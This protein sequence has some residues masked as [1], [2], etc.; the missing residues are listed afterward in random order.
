MSL[1]IIAPCYIFFDEVSDLQEEFWNLQS[2]F[3]LYDE[4]N[5]KQKV[6]LTFLMFCPIKLDHKLNVRCDTYTSSYR[7]GGTKAF[8]LKMLSYQTQL[9][10]YYA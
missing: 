4:T 5:R 2:V 1:K 6:F 9:S 8:L 7:V 10:N 3:P